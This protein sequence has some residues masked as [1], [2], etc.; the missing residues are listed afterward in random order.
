MAPR[1]SAAAGAHA[2]YGSEEHHR[3]QFRVG[4]L[5]AACTT[6]LGAT[7]PVVM[8]YGAV[9][10]DPLL[11]A[12]G[13][14]AVAA[15]CAVP[16]L[17]LRGELGLIFERRFLPWLFVVGVSGTVIT[18]ICVAYG[19]SEL[20]AVAGVILMQSE[21]VFSLILARLILGERPSLRQLLATATILL[22]IGSV[23][24]A[25]GVFSPAWATA[26]IL[27][28]PLF[29][30]ISHVLGLRVM[31][32]LRPI[33]V[34]GA[35]FV[36]ATAVLIVVLVAIRPHAIVQLLD[37]HRAAVIVVSGV[38][39]YFLGALTWYSA[40]SRLSLA[41]TTALVVP[42]MP[43]LSVV[44]AVMFLREGVSYR[45][46]FGILV[47]ISGILTLVLGTEGRRRIA[48]VEKIEAV[49]LPPA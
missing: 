4:L 7:F 9:N 33:T 19:L 25:R 34:T 43:L 42:G 41:W 15:C 40:I 10:L 36:F 44:F 8:R 32:P 38:F 1:K 28:S 23:F 12:T 27:V 3:R 17:H 14:A 2:D 6:V 48:P 20:T 47:A 24:G 13:S 30:Q 16:L 26:L 11:L 21:P 35:R 31:P 22:G 29:W 18:S 45:E 37:P 5:L 46:L 49:H 39:G